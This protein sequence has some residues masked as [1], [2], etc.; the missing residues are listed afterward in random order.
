VFANQQTEIVD[1]VPDHGMSRSWLLSNHDEFTTIAF[2]SL[3]SGINVMGDWVL[4]SKQAS[5]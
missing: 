4:L 1:P 2:Y 5:K 3:K